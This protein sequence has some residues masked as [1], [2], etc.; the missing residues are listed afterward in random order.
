M[1]GQR[2]MISL[3]R[4]LVAGAVMGA[5]ACT[6]IV[7][8]HGYIPLSEDL[9]LIQVGVD[10]RESVIASVGPPTANGVLDGSGYYYVASKFRHFGAF[11]PEEIDREVL[12][13][14]FNDAGVVTNIERF[15]L[16]DGRVVVLSRRV[17]DN[18]VRDSTFIR[19]LLGSIGRFNAGDFLGEG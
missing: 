16:E 4:L 9:A 15:G 10:T 17:T 18:G 14:S 3:R 5:V 6:P 1:T 2:V 8:N 11:E 12:A 19:Q 7:R 13:V